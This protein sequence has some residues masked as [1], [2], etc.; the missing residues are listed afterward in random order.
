VRE[1]CRS[2][3]MS[4]SRSEF[5]RLLPKVTGGVPMAVEGDVFTHAE[6]GRKWCSTLR[7]LP[8]LRAGSLWLERLGIHWR[9]SGYEKEE[10][11]AIVR[12]FELHFHRGGG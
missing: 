9:F 6:N 7:S 1:A 3:E 4:I 10:L 11:E 5:L 8:Q 2:F 12:R